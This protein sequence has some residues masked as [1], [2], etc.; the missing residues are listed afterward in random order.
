MPTHGTV[1]RTPVF[2]TGLFNHSSTP[3]DES[4][5][6]LSIRLAGITN[7]KATGRGAR[8]AVLRFFRWMAWSV[9]PFWA[10][11]KTKPISWI[12]AAPGGRT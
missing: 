9:R 6:V 1:A 5:T 12:M 4:M 2:K 8:T 11:C 3:P 7:A 10:F